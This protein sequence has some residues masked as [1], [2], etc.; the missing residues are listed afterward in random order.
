MVNLGLKIKTTIIEV[1]GQFWESYSDLWENKD[2]N[3]EGA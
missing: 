3:W 1:L 2:E